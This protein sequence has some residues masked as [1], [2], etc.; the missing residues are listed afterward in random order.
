MK[1]QHCLLACMTPALL[2]SVET[3][4]SLNSDDHT[5]MTQMPVKSIQKWL[6]YDSDASGHSVFQ[7]VFSHLVRPPLL[8]SRTKGA[9]AQVPFCKRIKRLDIYCMQIHLSQCVLDIVV[10]FKNCGT[11]CASPAS[12]T[13]TYSQQQYLQ[14]RGLSTSC[15]WDLNVLYLKNLDALRAFVYVWIQIA[16]TQT[17]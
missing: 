3:A 8:Q 4:T 9:D 14:D 13:F 15:S 5:N 7:T 10:F 11:L 12:H 2:H 6:K 16:V 1:Y 17:C